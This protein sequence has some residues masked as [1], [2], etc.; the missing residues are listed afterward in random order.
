MKKKIVNDASIK[1]WGWLA[2]LSQVF[3]VLN[4]SIAFLGVIVLLLVLGAF[5]EAH[6]FNKLYLYP[7]SVFFYNLIVTLVEFSYGFSSDLVFIIVP[8]NV[9][10]ISMFVVNIILLL[11]I[12]I[13][14]N[15]RNIK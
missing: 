12:I 7:L 5:I 3:L 1:F 15:D 9:K 10:I 14:K 4:V 6:K 2:F 8:E 11:L 13:L